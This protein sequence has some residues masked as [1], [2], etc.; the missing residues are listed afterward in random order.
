MLRRIALTATLILAAFTGGFV[1]NW[2]AGRCAS[3]AEAQEPYSPVSPDAGHATAS[4]RPMAG[5]VVLPQ[6]EITA[7]AFH[8]ADESGR[9]RYTLAVAY[10]SA[11]SRSRLAVLGENGRVVHWIPDETTF[12]PLGR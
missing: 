11:E 2:S 7:R 5:Q 9:V 3:Q 6:G 4:R 1:A 12:R 10:C 8:I